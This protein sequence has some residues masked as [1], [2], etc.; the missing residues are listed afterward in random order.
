M[1]FQTQA[2]LMLPDATANTNL[3]NLILHMTNAPYDEYVGPGLSK[4]PRTI[5]EEY[6]AAFKSSAFAWNKHEENN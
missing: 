3:V 6:R 4:I 2:R 1:G 5:L